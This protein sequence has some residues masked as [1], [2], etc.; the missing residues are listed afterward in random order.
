MASQ[1]GEGARTVLYEE[2]NKSSLRLG[3]ELSSGFANRFT[4]EYT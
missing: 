3:N 1:E 2:K 4:R